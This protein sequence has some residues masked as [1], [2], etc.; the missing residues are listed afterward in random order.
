MKTFILFAACLFFLGCSK[1][2]FLDTNPNP[3][4][5]VPSTLADYQAILDNDF[6]MNGEG[7][8]GVVPS[9]GETGADNYYVTNDVYNTVLHPLYQR[10]YIWDKNVFENE[11]IYDWNIPYQVIDRANSLIHS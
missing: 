1:T 6:T 11:Q 9:L 3:S 5:N 7:G 4:L 8:Y 10:A 2:K